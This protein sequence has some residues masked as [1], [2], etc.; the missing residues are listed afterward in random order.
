MRRRYRDVFEIQKV[1][2]FNWTPERKWDKNYKATNNFILLVEA[3]KKGKNGN[4][5]R[6]RA[7]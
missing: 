3:V 5:S 4:S 1:T 2:K 6:Q 7:A